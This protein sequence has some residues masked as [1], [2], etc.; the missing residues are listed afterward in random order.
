M[1]KIQLL[2]QTPATPFPIVIAGALDHPALAANLR[3]AFLLAFP[4]LRED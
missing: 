1:E 2:N 4:M 3:H